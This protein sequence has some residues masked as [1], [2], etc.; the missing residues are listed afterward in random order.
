MPPLQVDKD[1]LPTE[2]ADAYR[3][4]VTT[5]KPWICATTREEVDALLPWEP[6]DP[7]DPQ[8]SRGRPDP[9]TRIRDELLSFMPKKKAGYAGLENIATFAA[10]E[11]SSLAELAWLPRNNQNC[12]DAIIQASGWRLFSAPASRAFEILCSIC[13][14]RRTSRRRHADCSWPTPLRERASIYS[15]AQH[16]CD[17][18]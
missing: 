3:F 10:L 16:A 17:D 9:A 11:V 8:T 12:W 4:L 5:F 2:R 6:L 15:L 13:G 14:R 18:R 7:D 1:S